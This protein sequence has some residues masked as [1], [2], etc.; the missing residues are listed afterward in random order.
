MAASNDIPVSVSGTL[1]DIA[2]PDYRKGLAERLRAEFNAVLEK[3]ED[4]GGIEEVYFTSF[5]VQ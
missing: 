1:A 3:L 4:F 2:K 5:V